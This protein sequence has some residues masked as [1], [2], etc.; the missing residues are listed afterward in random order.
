MVTEEWTSAQE[1]WF[2]EAFQGVL[3][4]AEERKSQC[5]VSCGRGRAG[6]TGREFGWV[7]FFF[8][9][10]SCAFSVLCHRLRSVP[11]LA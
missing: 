4:A 1:F 10:L 2:G 6:M 8:T 11:N 3:S 5:S 7:F 9:L